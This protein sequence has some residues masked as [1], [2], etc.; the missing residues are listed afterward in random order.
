M[1]S[2][3]ANT[4]TTRSVRGTDV[5]RI[6]PSLHMATTIQRHEGGVNRGALLSTAPEKTGS[7]GGVSAWDASHA[8]GE[9]HDLA[10]A[11][12]AAEKAAQRRAAHELARLAKNGVAVRPLLERLLV[13]GAP[14]QRWGAVYALSLFDAVPEA[15]LPVLAEA[16]A[17]EDGDLRWAACDILTRR[18]HTWRD[19]AGRAL[20]DL[21]AA[22]SPRRRKMALYALRDGDYRGAASEW[23]ARRALAEADSDLRL[24]GL[25]ALVRLGEDRA[26]VARVVAGLAEDADLRVRRAATGTLGAL[27]GSDPVVRR[28]LQRAADDTDPSTA[29]AARQALRRLGE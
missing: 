7:V 28:A 15:A 2:Q 14:A 4:A 25:A 17:A 11:L 12:G 10:A 8:H 19:R 5:R 18:P 22:G 9:L 29:R 13:E 20:L 26:A 3:P 16:L 23:A 1:V 6:S 21:A 24:A 27:G